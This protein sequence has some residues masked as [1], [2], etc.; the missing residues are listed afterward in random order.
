MLTQED[1]KR[2]RQKL[3]STPGVTEEELRT[4]DLIAQ[5]T[6]VSAEAR[7]A[8]AK[9]TKHKNS[10]NSL[11]NLDPTL[12]VNTSESDTEISETSMSNTGDAS[13]ENGEGEHFLQTLCDKFQD[14]QMQSYKE[15]M[16]MLQDKQE[17]P[18]HH[19]PT[20]L[21]STTRRRENKVIIRAPVTFSNPTPMRS[22]KQFLDSYRAYATAMTDDPVQHFLGLEHSVAGDALV[23]YNT[24]KIMNPSH[25]TLEGVSDLLL[26]EFSQLS[27][28][29]TEA[30]YD[31]R[32]QGVEEPV[33]TYYREMKFLMEKAKLPP[34]AQ[35]SSFVNNL[36]DHLKTLVKQKEPGSLESALTLAI[37]AELTINAQEAKMKTRSDKQAEKLDKL[38]DIVQSL[39]ARTAKH[40]VSVEALFPQNRYPYRQPD[41]ENNTYYQQ[42]GRQRDRY[43]HREY[44]NPTPDTQQRRFGSETRS[45]STPP[46]VI[47]RPHQLL[48]DQD[49]VVEKVIGRIHHTQDIRMDK[50][51]DALTKNPTDHNTIMTT[52]GC[53]SRDI[54]V[55]L[56]PN[57]HPG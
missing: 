18:R 21:A 17:D 35:T 56:D 1:L 32:K 4:L 54:T 51:I 27:P 38:T 13:H 10:P 20:G 42:R 44:Q 12:Q 47:G 52:R 26:K 43:Q 33:K 34:A 24:Y 40:E 9:L 57:Q 30:T 29:E 48:T 5:G 25:Q 23:T 49:H 39:A 16:K 28:L 8:L 45:P 31:T 2:Y 15:F 50:T 36:A 37:D 41:Q 6:A 22:T 7:E 14:M 46:M 53:T 19:A 3:R 11:P 55:P